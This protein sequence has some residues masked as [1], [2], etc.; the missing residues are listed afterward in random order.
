MLRSLLRQS[1]VAIVLVG[2]IAACG[3]QQPPAPTPSPIPPTPVPPTAT[4][5]PIIE[6]SVDVLDPSTQASLR[7]VVAVPDAPKVDI[8]VGER[9]AATQFGYGLLSSA[10]TRAAGKYLIRVVPSGKPVS[11]AN[12]ILLQQSIDLVAR[13]VILG[14][15]GGTKDKLAWNL[16]IENVDAVEPGKSRFQ[17]VYALQGN[18]PVNISVDDQKP[19]ALQN[20]GQ[21]TDS[22]AVNVGKHEFKLESGGQSLLTQT[23]TLAERQ[24][25]TLILTGPIS[26]AAKMVVAN[27]PTI[28]EAQVRAINVSPDLGAV[29]VYVNDKQIAKALETRK[30][31]EWQKVVA[32]QSELRVLKAGSDPNSAPVYKTSLLL[33]PDQAGDIVIFDPAN[34]LQG[35]IFWE[36]LRPTGQRT[37]RLMVLNMA[38]GASGVQIVSADKPLTGFSLVR[39]GDASAAAAVPQGQL[40]LQFNVVGESTPRTVE[41]AAVEFKEGLVYVYVITGEA[42]NP[43]L[44]STQVAVTIE[45]T[46]TPTSVQVVLGGTRQGGTATP[47][48]TDIVQIRLVNATADVES[49]DAFVKDKPIT[50]NVVRGQKSAPVTLDRTGGTVVVSQSGSTQP[51]AEIKLNVKPGKPLLVIAVGQL[52]D[53]I[54]VFQ[55]FDDNASL[56]DKV[57]LQIIHA[58][59]SVNTP[60]MAIIEAAQQKDGTPAASNSR[61]TPTKP[62]TSGI[63]IARV[64]RNTVSNT[65]TLLPG[66]YMFFGRNAADRALFVRLPDATLDQGGV[67]VL[68]VLEDPG[69]GVMVLVKID[70]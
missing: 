23:L 63:P 50:Q 58:S 10:I 55:A 42:Q 1:I 59:D 9:I 7:F 32:R 51:L 36:N 6:Q 33:N 4:A 35:R 64:G 25:Y 70:K 11:D 38:R 18:A 57:I 45:P 8:Y 3:T 28:R 21:T 17:V 31:G 22:L 56:P 5:T 16:L 30:A 29:D 68:S 61:A 47:F 69:K 37:A 26:N 20:P 2:V 43:L 24:A 34:A 27:S 19:A 41:S 40:Q 15:I 67:Y 65:V 49:L 54:K 12:N 44:L 66:K 60:D 13:D 62:P 39:Y 52:P 53:K 46:P 48:P 14:I